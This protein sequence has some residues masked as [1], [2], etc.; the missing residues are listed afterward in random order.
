MNN[1][2]HA[3]CYGCRHK[4]LV[5]NYRTIIT[6]YVS[7]ALFIAMFSHLVN[8]YFFSTAVLPEIVTFGGV[9]IYV[10]QRKRLM[11][12]KYG[13]L[14]LLF[15]GLSLLFLA[16]M[17]GRG[18]GGI[19]T[20]GKESYRVLM[21]P[22]ICL[23]FY[24]NREYVDLK[25][26]TSV[27]LL[28]LQVIALYTI[29]EF[30][31]LNYLDR[32]RATAHPFSGAIASYYGEMKGQYF[33]AVWDY[34]VP[35]Y[36]PFGVWLQPQKS[37]FV[38][39]LGIIILFDAKRMGQYR[40]R[41]GRFAFWLLIFTLACVL[42]GGKTAILALLTLLALN[43]TRRAILLQI[44]V[45]LPATIALLMMAIVRFRHTFQTLIQ[46]LQGFLEL[47]S[48]NF[49]LGVGFASTQGLRT[50]GFSVESFA[51]RYV[52][53]TGLVIFLV[54]VSFWLIFFTKRGQDRWT[55]VNALI[56]VL[57]MVLHY[58]VLSVQFMAIYSA[59]AIA[60]LEQKKRI[61]EV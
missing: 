38:F 2:S 36:R 23:A 12:D 35:F 37:A 39:P 28:L 34:G 57:F 19:G 44:G 22:W 15:S 13:A 9:A 54:S 24:L 46:D 61:A 25:I 58:S 41:F 59:L 32:G 45:I 5:L 51:L 27:L 43:S 21:I 40:D 14:L 33:N 10:L 18:L 7:F 29:Y 16:I 17:Y 60:T 53:S 55:I 56:L 47:D 30:M 11:F 48:M 6:L 50:L 31:Q 49:L 26:V 52:S 1:K 3:I 42:S 4:Y 8:H 20:L